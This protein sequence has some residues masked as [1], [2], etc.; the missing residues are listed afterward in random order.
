MKKAL[1]AVLLLFAGFLADA[2]Q[3]A[4]V[5]WLD[6]QFQ[7]T[8]VG[9]GTFTIQP[10]GYTFSINGNRSGAWE[11]IDVT[12]EPVGDPSSAYGLSLSLRGRM[13]DVGA[14]ETTLSLGA[15]FAAPG[16][17]LRTPNGGCQH[18][19]Q[20]G[21]FVILELVRLPDGAIDKLA[22][23]FE[24]RC[25]Q[26]SAV[27]RAYGELRF[28]SDVPLSTARPAGIATPDP[29]SFN[30]RDTLFPSQQVISSETTIYGIN[31]PA[32]IS[33]TGGEYSVNGA[34]F[35][36]TPGSV[37][38]RDRVRV[39][40]NAPATP[41]NTGFA[42]V[43]IGGVSGRFDVTTYL[44]GQA[45][46]GFY[47]RAFPGDPVSPAITRLTSGIEGYIEK[48]APYFMVWDDTG[49]YVYFA[50]GDKQG[51]P[52][53]AGVYENAR[54]FAFPAAPSVFYAYSGSSCD[55]TGRFVVHEA[56]YSGGEATRLAVDFELL[57]MGAPQPVYGELR[58]NSPVPYSF[59]RPAGTTQ[60]NPFL[61]TA[62]SPV[63]PSEVVTTNSITV[64]GTNAA[65]TISIAG[66]EYSVNGG[67]FTAAAGTVQPLDHV[68]VR[69]TAS[70]QAGEMRTATLA[71]G[72]Q[73]ASVTVQTHR[74]G[75]PLS[76]FYVR[77]TPN[78]HSANIDHLFLAPYEVVQRNPL[79]TPPLP[80]LID[81]FAVDGH[82]A[83][84]LFEGPDG[85]LVRTGLHT[86]LGP[87]WEP[88]KF[89]ARVSLDST[90]IDL[91]AGPINWVRVHEIEY[92]GNG[93]VTRFA[94]DY[95]YDCG[96]ASSPHYGEVRYNSTVPFSALAAPAPDST[97]L[98]ADGKSDLVLQN[99]DG[100]IAA[101]TMDGTATLATA[102]LIGAGAGWSVTH[103]ADVDGDR[104]ADIFFKHTDGRVYVYRMDGLTVIAGKELFSAGLGWSISHTAD[105][106]GDGKADLILRHNDGRAHIWLMDGTAIIGS[107]TLL[108]ASSGWTVV[109][110]GDLN[111][112]GKADIV[113]AHTDGRGYVYLMNGTT[114]I[115]SAG[116]LAQ[117]SGWVVSHAADFDGDGK[118]DLLFRHVDGSAYLFLMNGTTFGAGVSVLGGGTGWSVAHVGDLN[119]DGKADLV[120]RHADGRAHARLMNGTAIL[121]A[122]DILPA[123]S[124]WSVTQL[125]DFNGDGKKDLVFRNDN[126]SITV[127]L[128]NGLTTIGSANL[129]GPGGWSVAP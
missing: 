70:A 91:T 30:P 114:I 76:G 9:G 83:G 7:D 31:A 40:A 47:F 17:R 71:I 125:L 106:N 89:S 46:T 60:P 20:R 77:T 102:N 52:A 87:S 74:T 62:Q 24:L 42:T 120:F 99:T 129:I 81:M 107:A 36:T 65:S 128:M 58:I 104:K 45:Q 109:A 13:F 72:G 68:K 50:V 80:V 96:C 8:V 108:P 124:G 113:F 27:P 84:I 44:P 49:D 28:N 54:D 67:A 117:G 82:R 51:N 55:V 11:Y 111:G 69:L 92:G 19:E 85:T 93:L 105:L 18:Q 39:R 2:A 15:D 116:F 56:T 41:G 119:G 34:A 48:S 10:P 118:A 14:Y 64:Y 12:A 22:V 103:L 90:T 63:V 57:C 75:T 5:L 127:R 23:N 32:S 98:S 38:N 16:Q 1:G 112:D 35:T 78:T 3:A 43:T 37:V 33:V 122:G 79:G 29:F 88:G 110:T 53:P 66:G 115:G 26:E 121:N 6:S 59:Q 101:W 25:G 95:N 73:G 94:A 126:G 86:N 100:R 97:D 61:L 123:A 4:N 21:R